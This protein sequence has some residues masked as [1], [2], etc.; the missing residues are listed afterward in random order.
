MNSDDESPVLGDRTRSRSCCGTFWGPFRPLLG[1]HCLSEAATSA[2][3]PTIVVVLYRSTASIFLLSSFL[4]YLLNEGYSMTQ[5]SSWCHIG[6]GLAFALTS[7][8]SLIFLLVPPKPNTRSTE[9]GATSDVKTS[10]M[11]AFVAIM[12]YQVFATSALFLGVVYWVLIFD[13]KKDSLSFRNTAQHAFNLGFVLLDLFLSLR[14]QFKLSYMPAFLLYTIA[15]L[16]FMWIRFAV[17]N[18][19]TYQFLDYRGDK[20]P[21][22]VVGYYLGIL[23]WAIVASV[24]MISLSRFSRLSCISP[25][26]EGA[27]RGGAHAYDPDADSSSDGGHVARAR[28]HDED[29]EDNGPYRI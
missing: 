27:R 10:S 14:M 6:L 25:L 23:V 16:V 19:F 15:Y 22:L 3:V 12:L 28:A 29:D 7:A 26:K 24:L 11:L 9:D 4:Y 8:V 5:Y 21:G 1:G 13:A 18:S 2:I 17:T 20:S